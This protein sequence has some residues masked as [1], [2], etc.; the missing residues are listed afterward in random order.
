MDPIWKGFLYL[1]SKQWLTTVVS[2]CKKWRNKHR[3]VPKHLNRIRW[4]PSDRRCEWNQL[5]ISEILAK[6]KNLH[7]RRWTQT[8]V[9][10]QTREGIE[11]V[12]YLFILQKNKSIHF[13]RCTR[14]CWRKWNTQNSLK[15]WKVFPFGNNIM[16]RGVVIKCRCRN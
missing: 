16:P 4:I 14:S 2:T 11:G 6:Q 15:R 5:D 3:V 1:G 9:K 10:L 8:V 13:Y 12:F 7:N